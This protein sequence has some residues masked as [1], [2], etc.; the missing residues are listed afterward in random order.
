MLLTEK[1]LFS[2]KS[3]SILLRAKKHKLFE[4]A[5]IEAKILGKG[6]PKACT[7]YV[8]IDEEMR[9]MNRLMKNSQ[10]KTRYCEYVT[11]KIYHFI[12]IVH[13]VGV[14]DFLAEF[15]EDQHSN[16]MLFYCTV[17]DLEGQD[18]SNL[19]T[20]NFQQANMLGNALFSKLRDASIQPKSSLRSPN[21]QNADFSDT[22]NSDPELSAKDP[23]E[24]DLIQKMNGAMHQN[25]QGTLRNFRV[26]TKEIKVANSYMD[27][28]LQRLREAI[29][30]M[31]SSSKARKRLPEKIR[32]KEN[33]RRYIHEMRKKRVMYLDGTSSF[34]S[35]ERKGNKIKLE[36]G[37]WMN[38]N[39]STSSYKPPKKKDP[40]KE[41]MRTLYKRGGVRKGANYLEA[42]QG[43]NL[44]FETDSREDWGVK[45]E[46]LRRR[47]TKRVSALP[48]VSLLRNLVGGGGG[49]FRRSVS[50]DGALEGFGGVFGGGG[51]PE[52]MV[53]W[54]WRPSSQ[55]FNRMPV[56]TTI[57]EIGQPG[58]SL[59]RLR[60]KIHLKRHLDPDRE[61]GLPN[62]LFHDFHQI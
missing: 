45:G 51:D 11:M 57:D 42:I 21:G 61:L 27:H 30:D 3:D 19:R 36:E 24:L 32:R 23:R 28:K 56:A 5:S 54:A 62:L 52:E 39:V 14:K 55:D 29:K 16:I 10:T 31:Q 43:K 35:T 34:L 37:K 26:N 59:D 25:F 38:L 8:D 22:E 9:F 49:D 41:L 4:R 48:R 12:K 40:A 6:L 2:A 58:L 47:R 50:H 13:E 20:P 7:D 15:I 33:L 1:S 53:K 46:K 18:F 17:V 44:A 60:K